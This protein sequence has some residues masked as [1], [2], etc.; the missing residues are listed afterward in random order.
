MKFSY[1]WLQSFFER[2]LPSP[3]I[4]SQL[5]TM[6]SFEVETVSR[7]K[8]DWVFDIDVLPNRAHDCLS[9]IGIAREI[10]AVTGLKMKPSLISAVSRPHLKKQ[11]L[12]RKFI[13]ARIENNNDCR[14]YALKLI[15]GVK[16]APSPKWMQ[17]RLRSCGLKPINN[18]VDITN[19]VMLE[20][21]Q[22][23]H[24][25]D[26][27]KVSDIK[28]KK[29][30][31]KNKKY[32]AGIKKIIVRRAKRGEKIIALDN[33]IYALDNSVLVIA[34]T[35]HPLAVAGIKG[36]KETSI[37]EDTKNILLE[38]ANFNP[39][40]IRVAS[41]KLKL[42][43]D[44]SWRF[45]N[46][47]DPNLIDGAARRVCELIQK[48]AGGRVVKESLDIYPRRVV[49]KDI[50]LRLDYVDDLLGVKVPK[51]TVKDIL[52]KLGFEV[53]E[54]TARTFLVTVPTRRLDVS[55][56]EDLIEEIGRIYGYEKIPS[57]L[58]QGILAPPLRNDIVFWRN[59]VKGW[60]K[61]AGFTEVYNY[62]FLNS[63]MAEIFGFARESLI[64]V[65]NPMSDNQHYLARSL[66]PRLLDNVRKNLKFFSGLKIFEVGKIFFK[67]Q[68]NRLS[69]N[70]SP[71]SEKRVLAAVL[72]RKEINDNG[73]YELKGIIETLFK[74]L[75]ISDV[76][77][78]DYQQKSDNLPFSAW[79][80][81]RSAEIKIGDERVGFLGEI[82]PRVAIE[83]GI[84][85]SVF[86]CEIDFD[87]LAELAS[88]EQ[89]YKPLSKY[90]AVIRDLSVL[91]PEGTKAVDVLNVINAAG[92][93]LVRDVDMFD[94][95]YGD[96]IPQGKESFS[97]HIVYQSSQRNL[98]AK[99]VG[100]L[101][102]KIIRAIESQPE[103][104]VR[105]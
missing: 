30:K 52:R 27:D 80:P 43:T 20:T 87:K 41:L 12:K 10:A 46:G 75:G 39:Q 47:I 85:G 100:R 88:E 71:F 37:G 54:R 73:F 11:H 45:E 34:D 83:M 19:Y 84:E 104:E 38:L 48:I 63:K 25:F 99:E 16:V 36:G 90:P 22:P 86:A 62:S 55:L 31:I 2:K 97:F 53:R 3:K 33:K 66:I 32:K 67:N 23:I 29:L 50:L 82:H 18:I 17:E 60:F 64:E 6:H 56:E 102:E 68:H 14:R 57:L 26:F 59:F 4:L 28:N 58:P 13:D 24:A 5:L 69:V 51:Q 61:E 98:T 42:R 94:I 78:D 35:K 103:W 92:G 93:E 44:A 91:V 15:F 74:S 65:K 105:R 8:K 9:H 49:P 72:A 40:L 70:Q 1:N 96:E 76:W 81:T 95:Y 7:L 101:Q 21:G 79:H 89:E 77:Y